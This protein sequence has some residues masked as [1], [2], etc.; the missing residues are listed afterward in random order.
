MNRRPCILAGYPGP[1]VC[2]KP[3]YEVNVTVTSG[4]GALPSDCVG[5]DASGRGRP[6]THFFLSLALC[7]FISHH[8]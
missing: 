8:Q 7:C 5:V 4:G 1:I 6:F 3:E 2:R